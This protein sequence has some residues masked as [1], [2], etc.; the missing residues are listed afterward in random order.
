MDCC[1]INVYD[2]QFNARLAAQELQHYREHG[3]R[4]ETRLLLDAIRAQGLHGATL[5]DIGGGIGAI[6]HELVGAG[7]V[8]QVIDVD[9]STPYL[10]DGPRRSRTPSVRGARPLSAR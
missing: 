7:V 3:P 1:Q 5:L 4:Q 10:D 8:S 2:D 9:A 6:Q